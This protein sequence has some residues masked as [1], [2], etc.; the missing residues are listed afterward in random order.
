MYIYFEKGMTHE[1]CFTIR[2]LG[3][4]PWLLPPKT[5]QQTRKQNKTKQ[6]KNQK[7]LLSLASGLINSFSS[8]CAVWHVRRQVAR[9]LR[10]LLPLWGRLQDQFSVLPISIDGPPSSL[11]WS[12]FLKC[13]LWLCSGKKAGGHTADCCACAGWQNSKKPVVLR[14][15]QLGA[16]VRFLVAKRP[17]TTQSA[18]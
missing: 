2:S 17:R 7:T 16:V 10:L 8:L 4:L 18:F 3:S 5:N 9:G 1:V 6:I 13:P 14:R 15:I 11:S 12:P